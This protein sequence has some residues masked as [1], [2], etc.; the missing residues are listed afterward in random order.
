VGILE[1]WSSFGA[2]VLATYQDTPWQT[3]NAT[4]KYRSRNPDNPAAI[5]SEHF[6]CGGEPGVQARM[7]SNLAQVMSAVCAASGVDL[8]FGDYYSTTDRATGASTP[9]MAIM[10]SAGEIR[11]LGELKVPWV[12]DH[13]LLAAIE[14]PDSSQ[15][16]R[17]ILGMLVTLYIG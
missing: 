17:H 6:L 4:I 8:T 1:H 3:L 10:T 2:E 13:Q 7:Q 5:D 12:P 11:A 16:L 15:S 14:R 9:D